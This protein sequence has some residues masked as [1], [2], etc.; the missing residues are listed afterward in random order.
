MRAVRLLRALESPRSPATMGQR[1]S[2]AATRLP[3]Q[4][5]ARPCSGVRFANGAPSRSNPLPVS[6]R[7]RARSPAGRR[8]VLRALRDPTHRFDNP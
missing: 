2:G 8:Q 4:A 3:R 7:A 1:R 5:T 6:V